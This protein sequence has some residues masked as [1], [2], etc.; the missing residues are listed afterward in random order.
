M[1]VV[2]GK[3][4]LYYTEYIAVSF[5]VLRQNAWQVIPWKEVRMYLMLNLVISI[6]HI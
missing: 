1:P 2:F 5:S 4:Y 6:Y 3:R